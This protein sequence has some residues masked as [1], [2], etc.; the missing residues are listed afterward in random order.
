MNVAS[1]SA[2]ASSAT[3]SNGD[4]IVP[5]SF[6]S[7]L[8]PD[9]S[10]SAANSSSLD[11]TASKRNC[12][13]HGDRNSCCQCRE[14]KTG[15]WRSLKEKDFQEVQE[16]VAE[17]VYVEEQQQGT[18][19]SAET[20]LPKPICT[21]LNPKGYGHSPCQAKR[22]TDAATFFCSRGQGGRGR[23]QRGDNY[24]LSNACSSSKIQG[25]KTKKARKGLY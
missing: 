25:S 1:A 15:D 7:L 22:K 18:A 16:I 17:D 20:P 2:S 5:E 21:Q 14:W 11:T 12:Y 8:A 6:G 23:L 24:G 13:H 19:L 3:L 10:G 4:D 9:F